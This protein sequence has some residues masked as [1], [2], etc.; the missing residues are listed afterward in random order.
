[1]RRRAARLGFK[2]KILKSPYLELMI[3]RAQT[4]AAESQSSSQPP[5]QGKT[6][7][8]GHEFATASPNLRAAPGAAVGA[9]YSGKL[10]PNLERTASR[11]LNPELTDDH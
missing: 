10:R 11:I 4:A 8:L 6:L 1:M 9:V 2:G 7:S 3:P 5:T